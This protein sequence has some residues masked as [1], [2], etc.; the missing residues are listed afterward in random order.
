MKRINREYQR[1]S[2]WP[3][4]QQSNSF[5]P[6][7]PYLRIVSNVGVGPALIRSVQVRVDGVPRRTWP[8]ITQALIGTSVPGVVYSSLN[9]GAVVLPNK[10]ITV[11][12]IPAGEEAQKFSEQTETPRLSIQICYSSLYGESWLSESL[13]EQPKPVTECR[14]D[15]TKEFQQ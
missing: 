1:I 14:P 4:I 10:D 6:G 2:V 3:R 7:Q 12:Q 9:A 11:L 5:V 8:E 13:E 15:P